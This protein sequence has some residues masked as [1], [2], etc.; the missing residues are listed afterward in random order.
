MILESFASGGQN[1]D[2]RR[3]ALLSTESTFLRPSAG[4][5]TLAGKEARASENVMLD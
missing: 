2:Y 4:R 5:E 1:L 3:L